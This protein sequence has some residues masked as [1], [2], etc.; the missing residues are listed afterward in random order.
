MK[1][2]SQLRE[3]V[4][5]ENKQINE[6]NDYNEL[7]NAIDDSFLNMSVKDYFILLTQHSNKK[8]ED[9]S[10]YKSLVLLTD[11]L[12]AKTDNKMFH[13]SPEQLKG[14]SSMK[15]YFIDELLNGPKRFSHLTDKKTWQNASKFRYEL[16]K[17]NVIVKDEE[18]L[19]YSF[20]KE[21]KQKH[22][23]K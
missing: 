17:A 21:Y 14:N 4:L 7:L 10:L 18:T 8:H 16:E 13:L 11:E 22:N 20:T 19:L 5:N 15:K 3:S 9:E 12:K 2:L 23:L 6:S 1:N